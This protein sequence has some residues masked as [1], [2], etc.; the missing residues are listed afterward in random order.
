MSEKKNCPR[1]A[2]QCNRGLINAKDPAWPRLSVSVVL[3]LFKKSEEKVTV[4]AIMRVS[5]RPPGRTALR[6]PPLNVILLTFSH[7]LLL[8]ASLQKV[9]VLTFHS[10]PLSL[11]LAECFPHLFYGCTWLNHDWSFF[12]PTLSSVALRFT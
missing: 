7:V 3:T 10:D 8:S 11:F 5:P 12:T 4:N 9:Q 6:N 2:A 1:A